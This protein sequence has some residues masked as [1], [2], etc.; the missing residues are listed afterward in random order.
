MSRAL[1]TSIVAA[2]LLAV[3]SATAWAVG[4]PRA[5]HGAGGAKAAKA[6]RAKKHHRRH[7]DRRG[8]R[9]R[10]ARAERHRSRGSQTRKPPVRQ[11]PV[12]RPPVKQ[13]PVKQ[14]PVKQPPVLQPPVTQPAID[15]FA[16][17]APLPA[18][19]K[20]FAP[21]SVWDAPV[22]ADAP[23]AADSARL[24]AAL[25]DEHRKEVAGNYGPWIN[26]T[27]W[28][29]AVYTVGASVPTVRVKLDNNAPALANDFAAVPMPA[30]AKAAGGGDKSL[31]VYQP[32]T[33][34]LWEFW[35]AGRQ[36]DGWHAV[37]GG[38][39]TNASK[40]PGYFQSPWGGS[41]TSLAL[42]GGLLTI[43]ELRTQRI[44]HA[45]AIAIPNTAAGTVTW[46]AQRGDG[47]TTG[48]TAIP[49][50]TRFRV[51]PS[52][53]LTK[54]GLSPLGLALARAAQRYGLIVR[55]TSSNIAF[56]AEDPAPTGSNPYSTLF[57][58]RWP[59]ELLNEIPWD[60]LQAVAP[61]KA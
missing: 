41:G 23:L 28:S 48:P 3:L 43:E 21:T 26:T 34:T 45:L 53:D 22:P 30:D 12:K 51:D 10:Y 18:G 17:V 4:G 29:I 38:K 9:S 42:L 58:G 39:M 57:G 24:S 49:E 13:P 37:W 15:P 8:G 55:D 7:R 40:N 5:H 20:P 50:G 47:R 61:P 11:P 35:L 31:V 27:E 36:A 44:D 59:N 32:A 60:H 33:D 54:L 14:P 56:Y 1:R 6:K 16:V 25:A 19:T 2:C 46:P 52:L